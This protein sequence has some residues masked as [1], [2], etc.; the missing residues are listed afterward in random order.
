LLN[1]FQKG[2]LH[3][4]CTA[5]GADAVVSEPGIDAI[6]MEQVVAM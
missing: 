4:K 6:L 1:C 3:N 2:T 5:V